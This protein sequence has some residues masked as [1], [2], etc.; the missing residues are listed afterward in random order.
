MSQRSWTTAQAYDSL[1]V[2][3]FTPV[4]SRSILVTHMR[5]V[6]LSAVAGKLQLRQSVVCDQL[7]CDQLS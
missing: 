1:S 5:V 4:V 3:P 2:L 7:W 6:E